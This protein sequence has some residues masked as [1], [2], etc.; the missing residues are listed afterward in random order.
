[1]KT[2]NPPK[3]HAKPGVDEISG[4]LGKLGAFSVALLLA[5]SVAAERQ[6]LEDRELA[7][8]IRDSLRG[9]RDLELAVVEITV[10]SGV[11]LLRGKVALLD[12]SLRIEQRT[13]RADGVVGV[14]NEL[15]VIPPHSVPDALLEKQILELVAAKPRFAAAKVTA[16]VRKGAVTLEGP[17]I[18][19]LR[20]R[21]ASLPGVLSIWIDAARVATPRAAP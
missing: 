14:E 15:R 19:E 7:R 16:S 5:T 6:A 17:G 13:W 9:A 11:V 21:I 3:P 4:G 8:Q 12:H 20:Q 18:L 1:V 10:R 2:R